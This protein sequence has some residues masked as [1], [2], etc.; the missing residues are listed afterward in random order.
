MSLNNLL[1]RAFWFILLI[2][3]SIRVVWLHFQWC[4]RNLGTMKVR[5]HGRKAV[6]SAVFESIYVDICVIMDMY[7]TNRVCFYYLRNNTSILG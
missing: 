3:R 4:G 2:W 7:S 5:L 1:W 6:F